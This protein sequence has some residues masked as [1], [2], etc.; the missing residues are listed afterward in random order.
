[1]SRNYGQKVRKW[2]ISTTLRRV[3]AEFREREILRST[4]NY[5]NIFADV[6]LS[7][8]DEPTMR[9]EHGDEF[10]SISQR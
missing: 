5:A 1:M 6:T 10:S 8:L 7:I 2:W 3:Y 9:N 4:M